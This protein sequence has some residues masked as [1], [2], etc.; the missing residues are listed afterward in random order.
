MSDDRS[1]GPRRP[2]RPRTDDAARPTSR[3]KAASAPTQQAKAAPPRRRPSPVAPGPRPEPR[4]RVRRPPAKSATSSVR[5]RDLP[6]G[7]VPVRGSGEDP[8][9]DRAR[10][11]AKAEAR[12]K[13]RRDWT[14]RVRAVRPDPATILPPPTPATAFR[15][16]YGVVYDT[17]GPRMRVGVLWCLV[18]VLSLAFEPA[19]PYGLAMVYGIMAGVAARQVVDAWNPGHD[20]MDRWAAA[21]GGAT[22]PVLATSGTRLLGFGL[23]VLVVAATIVAFL[24]PD[25]ER[26]RPVFA[27]AAVTVMAAGICGGAAAALVLL[28]NYEIGAVIILLIFL[29]V[30][31]ASDFIVGSGASNGVE[32]PLAGALFIFAT[33]MLLAFTEVPPFRGVDVWNFAM[34]A[35]VACPAGQL[36][37]SA[38]LPKAGT[39]APALRRIDS[40]L[41]AAP[42]WAGLIGL[43][44]QSSGH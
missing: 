18:V 29:M 23:M 42:A 39:K 33:S 20:G 28:A 17:H 26:G 24:R 41:V 37:A 3:A 8:S 40:M 11:G 22:L 14:G 25:D 34:L 16:R 21:L 43:Y 4:T 9:T 30:Y 27:S 19:R 5:F 2:P 6:T 44:L 32:G 1:G 35:A 31:D 36:L 12:P 13:V 7:E 15:Q 38:M 10:T